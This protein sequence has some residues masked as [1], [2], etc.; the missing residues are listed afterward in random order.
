MGRSKLPLDDS[1]VRI[2]ALFPAR[3]QSI[4][5]TATTARNSTDFGEDVTVVE[6]TPDQDM[7]VKFGGGAVVATTSDVFL[8]AGVVYTYPTGGNLRIA[9]IRD[10]ADGTLR[11]T[12][13]E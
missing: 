6:L 2:Q 8:A 3:A 12:E 7:F 11:I 9:A 4:T 10:T 5:V 13:L 1:G